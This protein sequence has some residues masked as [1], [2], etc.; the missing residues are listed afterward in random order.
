MDWHKVKSNDNKYHAGWTGYS[1]NQ[2]LFPNPPLFLEHIKQTYNV[3]TSLNLHPADGIA[4]H[5]LCYPKFR[6][7]F[8]Y[9]DKLFALKVYSIKILIFLE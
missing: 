6:S 8:K 9:V 3:K 2:E 1:W 5:E 4:P 7:S